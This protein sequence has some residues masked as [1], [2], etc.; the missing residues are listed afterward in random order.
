MNSKPGAPKVPSAL[1]ANVPLWLAPDPV[2]PAAGISGHGVK[3]QLAI[4]GA[5]QEILL[6]GFAHVGV[7]VQAPAA[8][9]R[10]SDS[11]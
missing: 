1:P 6:P 5:I 2:L 4:E 9:L 7:P 10:K 3:P 8:G 11:A